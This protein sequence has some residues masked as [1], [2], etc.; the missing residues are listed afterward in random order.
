MVEKSFFHGAVGVK[1][2]ERD[3]I[4]ATFTEEAGAN[5]AEVVVDSVVHEPHYIAGGLGSQGPEAGK[6]AYHNGSKS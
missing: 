1:L 2:P 3:A 6:R 5:P 4:G